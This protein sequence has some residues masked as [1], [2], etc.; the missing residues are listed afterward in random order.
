MASFSLGLAFISQSDS[1]LIL[2]CS[3][4]MLNA[5]VR[6]NGAGSVEFRCELEPHKKTV[7]AVQ[8]SQNGEILASCDDGIVHLSKEVLNISCI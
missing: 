3:Y 7:N 2:F 5:T 6:E 8:F 1:N 4:Y